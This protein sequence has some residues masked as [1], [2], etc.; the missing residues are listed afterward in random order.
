[1]YNSPPYEC[2]CG[3]VAQGSGAAVALVGQGVS[4]GTE[5]GTHD[6]RPGG[7]RDDCY[8]SCGGGDSVSA[9]GGDVML[10]RI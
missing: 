3:E 4:P 8:E 1:M 7:K 6:C 5:V 2:P 9:K 10:K